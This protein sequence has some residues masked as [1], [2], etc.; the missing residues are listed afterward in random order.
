M[1]LSVVHTM[2]HTR[3]R[4]GSRGRRCRRTPPPKER[5]KE[6]NIERE[7]EVG[8]IVSLCA[9]Y[10]ATRNDVR[11]I[12]IRGV[13]EQLYVASEQLYVAT[14]QLY[15][16]SEQLYVAWTNNYTWRQDEQLYVAS[17]ECSSTANYRYHL[18]R[19]SARANRNVRT[20]TRK[21]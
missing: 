13:D 6:R 16:A 14:E 2:V 21:E 7:R 4:A 10:I 5:E 17:R 1:R 20:T 11:R 18:P 12:T 8:R 9:C 15:V 19:A 3:R